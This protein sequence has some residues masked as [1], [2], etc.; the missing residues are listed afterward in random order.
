MR[1]FLLPVVPLVFL[2]CDQSL[3]DV[4]PSPN[5][6]STLQAPAEEL[7]S[8][9]APVVPGQVIALFRPDVRAAEP[10]AE[11]GAQLIRAMPFGMVLL[12]VAEGSEAAVARALSQNPN[13]IFAE[14][15]LIHV[16]DA[17]EL[18]EC[19]LPN[20]PFFSYRWD[21]HNDGTVNSS[22]GTE[23]AVTG[24]VDADVDW[25]EAYTVLGDFSGAAKVGMLDSGINGA[26]DLFGGR[27]AAARN[28]HYDIYFGTGPDPADWDDPD[29]HGSHTSG[30][31]AGRAPDGVGLR[32]IAYGDNVGIVVARV[33]GPL[34][35][36]LLNGCTE[37]AIIDGINWA[38]SQGAN[39]LNLS[40]GGTVASQGEQTALAAARNAGVL[41]VCAAG[42]DGGATNYP[43][44]FPE[45]LAVSATDWNDDR[46]SYSSFGPEII[47]SAPGGDEENADAYSRILSAWTGSSNTYA[48]AA[49]TSMAAPQVAGLATLLHALGVTSVDE[50]IAIMTSTADD[51]GPAG[52]DNEF[53]AGRINVYQAVLAA[54]AS[55]GNQPPTAD[56]SDSC[57]DLDCTFTDL[58]SD[59]DGSVVAWSWD[60]GDGN[61][62]S[63]QSPSHTYGGGG[64]YEVWLTVTDDGGLTHSTTK[65]VEVI[66]PPPPN[67]APEAGFTS[68][69][70]YLEC[71]FT[72]T[73][74]DDAAVTTWLWDFGDGNTSP[75]QNPSHTYAADGTYTVGLTVWD[76][77]GLSDA[78]SASVTV[79]ANQAPTAGFTFS[80][81]D[82]T[83]DFTDTSTDGDGTVTG[84]SWDF[85]DGNSSGAQSPS[86]SYA[87][88]GTYTVTLT[89]TDNGGLTDDASQD[90]EATDPPPPSSIELNAATRVRRGENIT[91]L[92][93]APKSLT[94]DV[95]RAEV[96]DLFPTVI[97]SGVRRG[98]YTDR[99][100]TSGPISF[101][102]FVCET[103]DPNNCSDLLTVTFP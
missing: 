9:T 35:L 4:G 39:V 15:N 48:L 30:I 5:P 86:H 47:V 80:C 95:W 101:F 13:V 41:P 16:L 44:A 58:S 63:T 102:Y 1:K 56:F 85:G 76:A 34:L 27:I 69:C 52:P 91:N 23:L 14:P 22:T 57:T 61:S 26:H 99:T 42:N 55:G 64:T 75:A 21:L 12:R 100:G 33:C 7:T 60:F 10:M 38:V 74:T 29:G 88:A 82:L 87:A 72:D 96:G 62:S 50:K 84:W 68:S 97:A 46:A 71:N 93:W 31:A 78:T 24:Q 17:C 92:T 83:C 37:A 65:D 98:K 32:G 103:G 90:V 70:T 19:P 51:L 79:A 59:P 3:L 28:F 94:V 18:G 49:G 45:C 66:G 43:A 54:G 67:E 2:A 81:T 25:L 89:A 20:D 36:G 6:E 77:E 73:S 8:Q 40:L 11:V 53:G